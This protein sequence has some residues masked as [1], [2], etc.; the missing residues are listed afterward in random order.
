MANQ[1]L[2]PLFYQLYGEKF[3]YYRFDHRM[4]MQKSVYLLQ[5]MG[6]P[7]GGYSFRWYQ[8]GPYSQRLQDDMFEGKNST[9]TNMEFFED[10]T[11][12]IEKLRDVIGSKKKG[13][14]SVS[15]WMECIAS[16]RYLR[17]KVL[18]YNASVKQVV[19]AL[20]AEKKHMD[21]NQINMAAYEQM[22]ALFKV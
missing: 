7:V 12:R 17:T 19:D 10:Y 14:Y 4:E 8:H 16:L 21:D 22:E 20:E 2:N 1:Y 9:E 5:D 18:R 13:H 15:Q 6:V 11:G 3:N